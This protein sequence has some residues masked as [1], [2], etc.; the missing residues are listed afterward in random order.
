MAVIGPG[1][2]LRAGVV[3]LVLLEVCSWS[4]A[5]AQQSSVPAVIETK[6]DLGGA[7]FADRNLSFSRRQ[8]CVSCHSPELAFTD[9]RQLG[10][11]QGAVSRGNDGRAL[12][13]RNAPTL[14]YASLTPPFHFNSAGQPVGGM[15]HDGRA[16]D[17]PV[18][19]GAPLINPVEMGMP[20]RASVV[21]RLREN[22]S[23]LAA[24]TRLFGASALDEEDKAFA[25]FGEALA[26]FESSQTFAPFDS[27]YDRALRGEAVLSD[28][29]EAGRALFFDS[30]R[31]SCSRCHA[32]SSGAKP[33]GDKVS[34]RFSNAGYFNLGVPENTNVRGLNGKAGTV[35]HGLMQNPA[36]ATQSSAGK[37]KVPTLR[38]VAIT[39]PYMHNGVFQELR[40]AILFHG[41]FNGS[42]P[43]EARNPE[44]SQPWA[45]PEVAANVEAALLTAPPLGEAEIKALIAFLS[46]LTDQRY[47]HLIPAP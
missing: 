29:E 9:P 14:G 1:R 24:F 11:V 39:G 31:S 7:L 15:F 25:A 13:D 3:F 18:Q 26:A 12:G 35:D 30:Q 10:A 28:E 42:A 40:T 27:K 8:N 36:A 32:A 19:A 20:D 34:E 4:N 21:A 22:P 17:L 44:T 43:Q 46:T 6:A 33:S 45:E 2:Q 16:A 41:R 23:Y 38:N 37:F 5:R 47:E